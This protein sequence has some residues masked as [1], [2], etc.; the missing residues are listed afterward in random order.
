MT[1]PGAPRP[2]GAYVV[3]SKF[4]QDVTEAGIRAQMRSQAL[5]GFGTAQNNLMGGL[6]GGFAN[7]ISAIFGTVN[8][9]YVKQ[10]P[11]IN[12]HSQSIETLVAAYERL[13]LQGNSIV[14]TSNGTYYPSEGVI[15]VDIIIIGGGA[16][17]GGGVWNLLADQVYGGGGGGGGGEVH[18]AIHAGLLPPTGGVPITVGAGGSGGSAANPGYGGGDTWFGELRAGGGQGGRTGSSAVGYESVGGTGMIRGG[19]GGR[20]A[21]GGHAGTGGDSTSPYDLHGGGGGGGGGGINAGPT[22]QPGGGGMGGISPGGAPGST[23]TQPAGIVATG[24][25]GGGGSS[26]GD[27]SGPGGYPSGGGGGGWANLT[28]ASRGGNGAAG[29]VFVIERFT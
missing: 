21:Y 27:S 13:I 4:G 1:A 9:S 3:G 18:A 14:F 25:G 29:I 19:H 24:A 10:L 11:I 20:G 17:G 5:G 7:I 6:L 15:S 28:S 12:D 8:N 2:D 16:G 26:N 23:G 22:W